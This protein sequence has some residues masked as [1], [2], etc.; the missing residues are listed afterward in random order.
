MYPGAEAA[1]IGQPSLR[2]A[3][4]RALA[5]ERLF[6]RPFLA[7]FPHNLYQGNI[8]LPQSLCSLGFH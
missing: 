3:V 5:V 4:V 8:L 7:A 1:G 6:A 2:A